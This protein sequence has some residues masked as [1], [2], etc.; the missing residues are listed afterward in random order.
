MLAELKDGAAPGAIGVRAHALHYN[1][2]LL[3]AYDRLGLR[4]DSNVVMYNRPGIEP[5]RLTPAI[6]E[7]PVFFMDDIHLVMQHGRAGAFELESLD[8]AS[9]GLKVF[10][11]HPH[12]VFLNTEDLARYDRAKA[13][14]HDP[15]GLRRHTNPESLRYRHSRAAAPRARARAVGRLAGRDH[16]RRLRSRRGRKR[17]MSDAFLVVGFVPQRID[18]AGAHSRYGGERGRLDRAPAQAADR[19][20]RS[21]ARSAARSRRRPARGAATADR[22]VS[23]A[24]GM[25]FGDKNAAYM[26]FLPYVVAALDAKIVTFCRDG[27]DAVRSLMDWH[28]FKAH[29]VYIRAEDGAPGPDMS[30]EEDPWGYAYLRPLPG[31]D[32]A[33]RWP[34]LDRFEKCAWY[35]A[36]YNRLLLERAALLPRSDRID[37]NLSACGAGDLARVFDFLELE[38]FDGG[39]V[40]E[41]LGAGINSLYERTG[42]RGRF[43]SWPDWSMAQ[44]ASFR[45]FAGPMMQRLGYF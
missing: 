25:K 11:L 9:P 30:P 26:P 27:R 33:S 22:G 29:N 31:D 15:D 24:E 17:P 5:Y 8:L 28:E 18:G 20:A 23:A 41:M 14:Y 38:G 7:L 16:V 32:M 21:P 1:Y 40:A 37:I 6:W 19:I 34:K 43:P 45:E 44:N 36:E 39:R 10:D 4:Y 2:R 13:S 42:I 3:A 12:H 35:W